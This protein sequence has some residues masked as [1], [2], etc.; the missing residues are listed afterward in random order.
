MTN[1]SATM[2]RVSFYSIFLGF[3]LVEGSK[4]LVFLGTPET[5]QTEAFGIAVTLVFAEVFSYLLN[6]KIRKGEASA[7]N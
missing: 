5:T 4:L 7:D 6:R 2:V 1:F 3:Y